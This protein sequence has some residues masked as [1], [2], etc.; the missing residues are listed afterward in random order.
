MTATA[1][2]FDPRTVPGYAWLQGG[3]SVLGGDV[4]ELAY[5]LDR[6]FLHWAAR[7]TGE[8]LAFPPGADG[9]PD[10][11]R[12]GTPTGL[13]LTTG[14]EMSFLLTRVLRPSRIG[15]IT[16]ARGRPVG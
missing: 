10:K 13:I 12:P 9:K 8:E 16:F 3:Q 7:W 4:L 11:T 6:L 5:R 15:L 1:V 14:S 2:C